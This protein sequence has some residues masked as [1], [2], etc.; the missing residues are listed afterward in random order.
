MPAAAAGGKCMP[1]AAAPGM[2]SLQEDMHSFQEGMH[3]FQEGMHS[4]QA[5]AAAH[6][7]RLHRLDARALDTNNHESTQKRLTRRHITCIASPRVLL[8][9]ST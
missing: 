5:A 3:S 8:K 9:S 1:A 7:Q 4:S 6:P 2:H